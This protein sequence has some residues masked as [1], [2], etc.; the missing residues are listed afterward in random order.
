MARQR[1]SEQ[2]RQNI[3]LREQAQRVA[4]IPVRDLVL[5]IRSM[6]IFLQTAPTQLQPQQSTSQPQAQQAQQAQV[7]QPLTPQQ[8]QLQHAQISQ[9]HQI[10]AQQ[11]AIQ[12]QRTTGA[13]ST[14]PN[15]SA[16]LPTVANAR[17]LSQQGQHLQQGRVQVSV[18]L[19][20]GAQANMVSFP[21][22]K[23]FQVVLYLPG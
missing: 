14:I 9:L 5:L 20:A 23:K 13:P 11:Q 19:Q 15:R 6:L 16:R 1:Q 12:S 3:L 10:Q 17:P 4:T 22:F 18:P 2:V 8:L 7:Q 21:I